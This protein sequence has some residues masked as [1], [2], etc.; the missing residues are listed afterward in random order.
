MKGMADL[1]YRSGR[2]EGRAE[3][4]RPPFTTALLRIKIS[5]TLTMSASIDGADY[6]KLRH[7]VRPIVK[8][9][10]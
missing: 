6:M 5:E 4:A 7:S 1:L 3:Q 2:P 10:L 8:D 9:S